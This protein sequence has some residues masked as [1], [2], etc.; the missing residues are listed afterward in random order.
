MVT[1]EIDG[2]P[3]AV[4]NTLKLNK[5][6]L[7]LKLLNLPSTEAPDSGVD[8]H[9]DQQREKYHSCL[10]GKLYPTHRGMTVL[11]GR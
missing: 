10:S 1:G 5:L 2:G 6:L 4:A 8:L 9:L 11:Y 3:C 7:M